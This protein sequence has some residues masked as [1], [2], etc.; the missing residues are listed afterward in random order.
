MAVW[1]EPADVATTEALGAGPVFPASG[2]I[3]GVTL[4][5]G[6]RVLVKDQLT[7]TENGYYKV[8]AGVPPT[9]MATGDTIEAEDVIRVSQGDRNAHTAWA[10]IDATNRIFVR[11]DVKNYSF[12]SI[13]AL[14]QFW[15]A[16]PD[17]IASV[18]GY[19]ERGD[20]GGGDFTFIGVLTSAQVASAT[21]VR[22]SISAVT[23]IAG[24]V[25]VTATAH[26]LGARD[27]VT[28][29]YIDGV[30]ALPN[31]VYF[32]T[33]VDAN[34]F[35]INGHI[36]GASLVGA[37]TV[38]YVKLVTSADHERSTGQRISVVG[39]VNG[40]MVPPQDIRGVTDRCGVIN[41]T[42]LSL[43]I[44]NGGTGTYTPGANAL[45][46]D[47]GLLVPA[48]SADGTAGGLWQR[49]RADHLDVRWFGAVGKW[50]PTNVFG[51]AADDLAA[52]NAAIAAF[53]SDVVTP[54]PTP[55]TSG[56]TLLAQGNF[57]LSDTLHIS[58]NIV[59]SGSGNNGVTTYWR[60]GTVLAFPADK[61]GIRIHSAYRDDSP[62]GGSGNQSVIR[63]LI[64]HCFDRRALGHGI[65]T[66]AAAL[67][68]NVNVD[69]FGGHGIA[70]I[71]ASDT[72]VDAGNAGGFQISNCNVGRCAG[73]GVHVYGANASVGLVVRTTSQVN[74]GYGFY[75]E[76]GAGNTYVAL[77][78]DGN[79]VDVLTG[80]GVDYKT[81]GGT[82]CSIFLGCYSEI[83][84]QNQ[85]ATPSMVIGGEVATDSVNDPASDAFV[86]GN[87]TAFRA[88]V[89]HEN[90]KGATRIR[91]Q[92]GGSDDQ[93]VALTFSTPAR[94]ADHTDLMFDAATNW[95]T[96][97]NVS[98]TV[99]SFPTS[100]AAPRRIA[101]LFGN[102][103][104]YGSAIA[105]GPKASQ[106][107]TNHIVGTETLF[108]SDTWEKGD[109]V[110]NSA[111]APGAPIGWVCTTRGTNGTLNAGGTHGSIAMG[112]T[113][114]TLDDVT[115]LLQ[116]QYIRIAGVSGI[117]QIVS[118][119]GHPPPLFPSTVEIDVMADATVAMADVAFS[120]ADFSTFGPVEN[121]G[122]S[123]SYGADQL[124]V[125]TDRY[126]TVTVDATMTLP[127]SP[128]D[129]Q[130]HDIKSQAFITTTVDGNGNT[131]DGANLA[132][133]A[134]GENR[135]FRYS[136][137][138]A[139]WEIR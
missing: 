107:L 66:S 82:N 2:V 75:D 3:D 130:M 40:G 78:G 39:V 120:P 64:V 102:G 93:M 89:V 59:L 119:P 98:R 46:G 60:P 132:T 128:L 90:I 81:V 57:Y 99:M 100:I 19:Y 6:N 84:A 63:D 14:K 104:F 83:G 106:A 7:S 70:V 118:D 17:A 129:G 51:A 112:T 95:W 18:A 103:I 71:A 24:L 115:E 8:V 38:Q 43:P 34:N 25:S 123:T 136:A 137:A 62:D 49:A 28:T 88:P 45:I 94:A 76:T 79:H 10:L 134:A 44:P 55:T 105:L 108:A 80:I 1:K 74:S 26:G 91:A 109:I 86:F 23:D 113:R 87:G 9:L 41:S 125:L 127:A 29:T 131:I 97:Q 56:G 13:A 101:P 135:T 114:L 58:R 111:P 53:G 20:K 35:T 72:G 21:P 139:E 61:T 92:L 116:W 133:I 67:I 11:Q 32:I 77:H 37:A 52:F 47:D 117:K 22:K 33:V 42:T 68:E 121:V 126:V 54:I 4:N 110:W 85:V 69:N 12:D 65:H 16:L 30:D 73:N 48:G 27:T 122:N 50:D 138:A 124:L 5:V 15:Q 96:L 36:T 31:G